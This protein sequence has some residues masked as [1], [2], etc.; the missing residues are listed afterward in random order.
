[1]LCGRDWRR[2]WKQDRQIFDD[3]VSIMTF[4]LQENGIPRLSGIPASYC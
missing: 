4:L 1:V 2:G 3:D